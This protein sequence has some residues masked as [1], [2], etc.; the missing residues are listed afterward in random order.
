L[1]KNFAQRLQVGEVRIIAI[2]PPATEADYLINVQVINFAD[3]VLSAGT[4][5]KQR[6]KS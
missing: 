5:A 1:I 2:R 3:S 4:K 6:T